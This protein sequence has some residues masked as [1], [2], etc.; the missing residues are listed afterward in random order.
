[1]LNSTQ[2]KT[3]TLMLGST[4]LPGSGN[5]SNIVRG[6]F[7]SFLTRPAVFEAGAT[8]VFQLNS[9]A[10][11]F[12]GPYGYG[13]NWGVHLTQ[14]SGLTDSSLWLPPWEMSG[15]TYKWKTLEH[16]MSGVNQI[17]MQPQSA[18]FWCWRLLHTR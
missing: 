9:T 10:T 3:L 12:A 5:V 1:M 14:P 7:L 6:T 15:V 2:D 17:C 13:F 18:D 8:V 11:N 4:T 16:R